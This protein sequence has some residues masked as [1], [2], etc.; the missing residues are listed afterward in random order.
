MLIIEYKSDWTSRHKIITVGVKKKWGFRSILEIVDFPKSM[1]SHY[2]VCLK[3][4]SCHRFRIEDKKNK[5]IGF[6][7]YKLF[8]QGKKIALYFYYY[9]V[10]NK[11][12]SNSGVEIDH[13]PFTDGRRQDV[14]FGNCNAL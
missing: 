1:L 6:G 4:K 2:S 3:K 10:L 11:Q 5:G 8:W 9:C 14:V 7:W 12:I 13:T